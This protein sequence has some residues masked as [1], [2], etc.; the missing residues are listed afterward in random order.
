MNGPGPNSV[1]TNTIQIGDAT[2]TSV[3]IGPFD[4]SNGQA[5]TL[6][7]VADAPT[8]ITATDGTVQY[9]SITAARIVTLPAANA[10]PPGF[11]I[12][13]IDASGSAS[14]V[15]TI[16]LTRAG[17]DTINGGTTAAIVNPYGC[18][19]LVSDGISKWTVIRSL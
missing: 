1:P 5:A 2:N 13:V 16:T 14:A 4:F 11:R 3:K 7:S 8:T 6:R 9:S 10:V 19:E 12:L 15:N 17:A 18:R